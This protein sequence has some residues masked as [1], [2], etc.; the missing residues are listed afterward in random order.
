MLGHSFS[1]IWYLNIGY[2]CSNE[3]LSNLVIGNAKQHSKVS[4]MCTGTLNMSFVFM[5]FST[6]HR[7]PSTMIT[8]APET[9]CGRIH[10]LKFSFLRS[11]RIN[12]IKWVATG[13]KSSLCPRKRIHSIKKILRY[14]VLFNVRYFGYSSTLLVWFFSCLCEVL[15][16][17][18]NYNLCP[19]LS[20]SLNLL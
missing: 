9:L 7:W 15:H 20:L 2:N 1:I 11:F 8:W 18:L 13:R 16:K 12:K 19:S 14:L 10:W 5:Y 3:M 6:L 4:K 17:S